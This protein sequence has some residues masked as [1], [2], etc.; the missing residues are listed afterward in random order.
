M[1]MTMMHDACKTV[2]TNHSVSSISWDISWFFAR[3]IDQALTWEKIY[4]NHKLK[5]HMGVAQ[6]KS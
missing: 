2:A 6:H 3:A 5:T 4:K 1:I